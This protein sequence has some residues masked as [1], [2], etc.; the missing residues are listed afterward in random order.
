MVLPKLCIICSVT[1]FVCNNK[2]WM[3]LYMKWCFIKVEKIMY[4]IFI[5]NFY[6]ASNEPPQ[7]FTVTT[8]ILLTIITNI[9]GF[10]FKPQKVHVNVYFMVFFLWHKFVFSR[11]L[12]ADM[13][14][15]P[16]ECSKLCAI[17]SSTVP[18]KAILGKYFIHVRFRKEMCKIM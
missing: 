2:A 12:T 4:I 18:I 7:K 1:F 3:K 5:K 6:T 14:P 8:V 17:T 9:F 15:P 13:S 11:C 10:K 16:L